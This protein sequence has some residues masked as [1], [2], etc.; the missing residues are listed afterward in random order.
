MNTVQIMGN[1]TRD[2]Q[3]GATNGGRAVTSFSI[4]V[5]RTFSGMNGERREMTDFIRVVAWG[6]LAEA[7]GNQLRKGTRVFVEGRYTSRSYTT[8]DGQKHYVTEV[9]ANMIALPLRTT[10]AA[11][12]ACD[13][14]QGRGDWDQFGYEPQ[15]QQGTPP[16]APHYTR[17]D[18]PF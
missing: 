4:A 16:G 1:L 17:E 7:V 10:A 2:P 6:A 11:N 13:N 3:V 15:Y 5:N 12:P 8:P 14:G 18:I 9:N